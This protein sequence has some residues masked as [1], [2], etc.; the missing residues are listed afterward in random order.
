LNHLAYFLLTEL[1]FEAVRAAPAGRIINVSSEIHSAAIDFGNLQGEKHYNFLQAYY[2][3]KLENILFTY[4]LA[5]RS[6]G[7]RVTVNSLSPG[8][9]RTGFGDGL[10]GA[11]RLFPL[12]MK[13]IPFLFG[14]VAVGARMPVY[15]ATSPD[16]EGV[17]GRFFFRGRESRTKPVSYDEHIAR[18]LWDIS[19]ELTSGRAGASQSSNASIVAVLPRTQESPR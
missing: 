8:P 9:T 4:E 11:A 1:L 7:T 14:P 17:S 3:S 6:E 15:L 13:S 16:V 5:R 2:Q 18:R 10:S 12:F 19:A